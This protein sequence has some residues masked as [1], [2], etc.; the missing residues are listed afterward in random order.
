MGALKAGFA[1]ANIT[2]LGVSVPLGGFDGSEFRL[3]G[4]VIDPLF[5]RV[6]ALRNGEETCLFISMDNGEV[7]EE[8]IA[9]FREAVHAATGIAKDHI[10]ISENHTHSGPDLIC[11]TPAALQHIHNEICPK[12][13][14][15]AARALADLKPAK[16]SYGTVE[17]GRPGCRFTF[18][19]HYYAVPIE[20]KD[21]WTDADLVPCVGAV[22]TAVRKGEGFVPVKHCEEAD[23][24]MHL[25]RFARED[26]DDIVVVNYASHGTFVGSANR[27]EV[28]SDWTGPFLDRLEELLPDV[29][30]AFWQGCCGN[31]VPSTE[32]EDEGIWCVTYSM[33]RPGE[34]DNLPPTP[35]LRPKNRS[36]YAYAAML[37]GYAFEGLTQYMKPSE[38]D[39]LVCRQRIFKGKCDHSKDALAPK[40]RQ[41]LS[42]FLEEGHTPEAIAHCK[43]FGLGSLYACEAIVRRSE[44]P[45]Y[46]DIELNAIEI[47]D[48]AVVTAPFENYC[49]SGVHVKADSPYNMTIFS[50]YCCGMQGYLPNRNV[51]PQHYEATAT[52]YEL[53]T[54]E[55]LEDELIG[56]LQEIRI[57]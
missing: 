26:A 1:R 40:A 49:S 42:R 46:G 2:P 38:T 24:R 13:A 28:S 4:V 14:D 54:A 9:C 31:L 47:G 55:Q 18:D 27:P 32:I 45:E 35:E 33:L 5:A 17:V 6:I 10:Y 50:S 25:M 34:T 15:A 41:A 57:Q 56:M 8:N 21:N 51:H 12:M 53:G 44:L 20:K 43:S 22:R 11:K 36:H 52:L 48:C 3:S 39:T 30:C 7:Y 29:K 23:H 19:R 16:L 37:A